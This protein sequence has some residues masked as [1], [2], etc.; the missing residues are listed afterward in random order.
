MQFIFEEKTSRMNGICDG[1]GWS[2]RISWTG[3]FSVRPNRNELRSAGASSYA[4]ADG[5]CS[6]DAS[7]SELSDSSSVWLLLFNCRPSS[8]AEVS[9]PSYEDDRFTKIGWLASSLMR[10]QK[11]L[12]I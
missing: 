12:L 8:Y 2:P 11:P 6:G 10:D 1:S 4:R 7:S 5:D 3:E 9:E